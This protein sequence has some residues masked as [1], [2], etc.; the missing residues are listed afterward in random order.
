MLTNKGGDFLLKIMKF[1]KP[2]K[3]TTIAALLLSLFN[4]AMQLILPALMAI[5]INTGIA[6][7]NMLFV[8]IIGIC[9]AVLSAVAIAAAISGRICLPFSLISVGI[10][11]LSSMVPVSS[12]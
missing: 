8:K 4:N 7:G 10:S 2:Y 6:D 3:G 5:M 1:L 11:H 9:M 12:K